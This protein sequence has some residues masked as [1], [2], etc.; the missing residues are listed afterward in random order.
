MDI[1]FRHKNLQQY[2]Q[3]DHKKSFN[4]SFSLVS[5]VSAVFEAAGCNFH[6]LQK[7]WCQWEASQDIETEKPSQLT[8]KE[9]FKFE[10]KYF[11]NLINAYHITFL[12]SRSFHFLKN[13][14]LNLFSDVHFR[15]I[16]FCY[17]KTSPNGRSENLNFF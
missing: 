7:I 2:W 5:F 9:N 1:L 15:K 10:Y 12:K 6:G 17:H 4:N 16:N 14:L 11:K 3:Q 13:Y 8:R